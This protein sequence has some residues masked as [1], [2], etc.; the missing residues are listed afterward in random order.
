M[1]FGVT[2]VQPLALH[3]DPAVRRGDGLPNLCGLR[4]DREEELQAQVGIWQSLWFGR[5]V[6]KVQNP[7][8]EPVRA[9][10]EVGSRDYR[11]HPVRAWLCQ[12]APCV[13]RGARTVRSRCTVAKRYPA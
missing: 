2:P 10:R 6:R 9:D 1:S 3:I 12:S 5:T 7:K 13:F 11:L 8:G 4:F